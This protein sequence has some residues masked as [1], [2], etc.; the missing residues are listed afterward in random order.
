MPIVPAAEQECAG[1]V[2]LL[3]MGVLYLADATLQLCGG[4]CAR[5]ACNSEQ[6]TA[7]TVACGVTYMATVA[8]NWSYIFAVAVCHSAATI[9]HMSASTL[10]GYACRCSSVCWLVVEGHRL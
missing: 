2:V 9:V 3:G 7:Q 4:H 6:G 10:D 1:F 5:I 8:S